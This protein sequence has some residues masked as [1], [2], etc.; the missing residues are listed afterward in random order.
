MLGSTASRRCRRA[1]VA[2]CTARHSRLDHREPIQS[3]E[4]W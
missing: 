3:A 1:P 4:H 2:C